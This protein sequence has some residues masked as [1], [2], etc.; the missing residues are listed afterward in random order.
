MTLAL[1]YMRPSDIARVVE[2]D[3]EAFTTPWSARSYAY[4]IKESNYSHMA[5]LVDE[6]QQTVQGWKRILRNLSGNPDDTEIRQEILAYGGL[7]RIMEEAHISTIA[8]ASPY[9]GKGY[10]EV[11]LAAMIKRSLTL[12][13]NYIVLEV[14]VSNVVAQKLYQK[15]EFEIVDKKTNY[16]RDDGEDAYDMRLDLDDE[17]LIE[18]FYRRYAQVQA[19]HPFT[20][21]YTEV[22]PQPDML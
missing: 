13:A 18:R 19:T 7:W 21:D 16:Y 10:G 1:R 17:A 15:Y 8:T 2:I 11:L 6:R 14:R 9:R 5:V 22:P 4:E 20:D 12:G 3:Q